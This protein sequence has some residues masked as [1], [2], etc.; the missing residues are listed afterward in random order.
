MGTIAAFNKLKESITHEK[1]VYFNPKRLMVVRVQA[2]YHDGL[3][4][5]LFQ[6]SG[7]GMQPVHYISRTMTDTEKMYYQ[8]EKGALAIRRAKNWFKM[9][10]LGAQRFKIFT[11]RTDVCFFSWYAK[12]VWFSK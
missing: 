5:G 2:S 3:S 10:L 12:A 4:A 1:M 8:T 6:K 9:H 7:S 11:Y